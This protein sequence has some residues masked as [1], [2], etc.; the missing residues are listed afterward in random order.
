MKEVDGGTH[1]NTGA[2]EDWQAETI[3]PEGKTGSARSGAGKSEE[4]RPRG[5]VSRKGLGCA[6]RVG[7]MGEGGH[8][9]LFSGGCPL[10]RSAA[11]TLPFVVSTIRR[12]VLLLGS[13]SPRR[14]R[15]MV[16]AGSD[17]SR[18]NCVGLSFCSAR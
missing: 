3:A 5:R 7:G 4:E 12:M 6:G 8:A 1:G 2:I 16:E 17:A 9:A 18:A 10:I 15:V 13:R 14:M 11:V